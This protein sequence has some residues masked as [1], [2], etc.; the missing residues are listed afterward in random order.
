MTT[1]KLSKHEDTLAHLTRRVRWAI[2]ITWRPSV[3]IS[4]FFYRTT[5]ANGTK[6][7]RNVHLHG[8]T[9]C[10]YNRLS[11]M[12]ARG[13]KS[14]ILLLKNHWMDWNHTWQKCSWQGSDQL[15]LL[16]VPIGYPMW[17]PGAI[18]ASDWLK[19]Q[20]SS[21]PMLHRGWNWK[22]SRMIIASC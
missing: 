3:N 19:F 17:L 6:R 21:S 20:R 1:R 2:A 14:N 8:L 18:I 5:E 15:L 7:G 4:I 13:H 12:A 9:K 10:C 11:N 22:L 16:F